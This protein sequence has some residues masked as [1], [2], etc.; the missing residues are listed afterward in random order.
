MNYGRWPML[1]LIIN[2]HMRS[3]G[4]NEVRINQT[5]LI[6]LTI[7]SNSSFGTEL[8]AFTFD[9]MLYMLLTEYLS[10]SASVELSLNPSLIRAYTRSSEDKD[11]FRAGCPV[12]DICIRP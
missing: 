8:L 4:I 2:C 1:C 7:S 6:F 5:T 11:F 12:Q 9:L 10:I 3:N